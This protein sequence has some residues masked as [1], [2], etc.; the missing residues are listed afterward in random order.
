MPYSVSS[1]GQVTL[2]ADIR[3]R[4]GIKSGDMVDFPVQNG[5][6]TV[7]PVHTQRK[8]FQEWVGAYPAFNSV[9]EI[10]EHYSDLRGRNPKEEEGW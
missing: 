9:D 2:P 7:V 10:N 6:V 3:R 5:V 8:S 1:Q 4:L